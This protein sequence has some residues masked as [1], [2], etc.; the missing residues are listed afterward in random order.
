[1]ERQVEFAGDQR[2]RLVLANS[3]LGESLVIRRS[4]A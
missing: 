1:M 3:A 2:N 4:G